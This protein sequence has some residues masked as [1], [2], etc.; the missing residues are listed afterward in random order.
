[1]DIYMLPFSQGT[2]VVVTQG[3][4][5][6]YSH[7]DKAAYAFDFQ[8]P[9]GEGT[10]LVAALGG[11]VAMIKE[12]C[13]DDRC[14][15]EGLAGQANHLVIRHD[16]GFFDLYTHLKF[17]SISEFGLSIGTRVTRGQS[18]ARLG[19][20]GYTNCRPH[21]HFQREQGGP[22]YWQQS[23]PVVF[24]DVPGDG[25]PKQGQHYISGNSL[26][27]PPSLKNA[28]QGITVAQNNVLLMPS[29]AFKV[30]AQQKQ[31]G[32]PLSNVTR[33]TAPDG[34]QYFV[35][36]FEGDTVYVHIAPPDGQTDWTDVRSMN[37]LLIENRSDEW[38][39]QLWKQTYANAG[40][41][42][43]PSWSSHQYVLNQLLV[44]PLGAPLGGGS[45]NGVHMLPVGQKHYEAE[46]YARD[47]IYW[48]PPNWGDI[49]RL[50][51][52]EEDGG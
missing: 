30:Y 22:S 41:E 36:V 1:M 50:S 44:K 40:V 16:D 46:V 39:I 21:L 17:G 37:N 7:Y 48:T 18:V 31:L 27:Q 15:G 10:I 26:E 32:A 29:R 20:T 3:N 25:I 47:T 8:T 35:Q 49:R 13:P 9:Q 52:L 11:V 45:T 4:N 43:R 33:L 12:D 6:P 34:R 38:G 42:F 2:E 19:K 51:E 5:N 23:V 14:G 24:A 28:L